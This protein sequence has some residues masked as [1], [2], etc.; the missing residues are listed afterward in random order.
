MSPVKFM[1]TTVWNYLRL[2]WWRVVI[3]LGSLGIAWWTVRIAESSG[4]GTPEGGFLFTIAGAALFAA[5]KSAVDLLTQHEAYLRGSY[6]ERAKAVQGVMAAARAAKVAT[7]E[8]LKLDP[9]VYLLVHQIA[10]RTQYADHRCDTLLRL[11][12]HNRVWIGKR[13][14]KKVREFIKELRA[15]APVS[16]ARGKEIVE[17]EIG[18]VFDA[19]ETALFGDLGYASR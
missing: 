10:A 4:A 16:N 19:L 7:F 1:R 14:E 6:T 11:A 3:L 12:W 5:G 2:S 15:I 8:L 13:G 9:T 18:G 17:A